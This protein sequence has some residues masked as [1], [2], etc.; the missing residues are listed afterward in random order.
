MI[1]ISVGKSR[2]SGCP[3]AS[4]SAQQAKKRKSN[5]TQFSIHIYVGFFIRPIKMFC[6]NMTYFTAQSSRQSTYRIK[7]GEPEYPISQRIRLGLYPES[8][9]IYPKPNA[10]RAQC[11]RAKGKPKTLT[12]MV[13]SAA[14]EWPGHCSDSV[15]VRSDHHAIFSCAISSAWNN[16]LF[17]FPNDVFLPIYLSLPLLAHNTFTQS[18]CPAFYSHR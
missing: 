6:G 14:C 15:I 13:V 3:R 1:R 4:K 7:L 2:T 12:N 5:F 18:V 16:M 9:K 8:I 11:A 10:V 17:W